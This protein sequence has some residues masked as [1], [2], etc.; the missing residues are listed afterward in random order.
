V[1]FVLGY[2]LSPLIFS[3]K[4]DTKFFLQKTLPDATLI[5]IKSQEISLKKIIQSRKAKYV[6]VSF[7]AT[8]CDPC[9]REMPLMRKAYSI[10]LK[11][12]KITELLALAL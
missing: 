12:N 10:A 5:D 6:L 8:W 4:N 1:L 11:R 7:W 9:L 3:S 2:G